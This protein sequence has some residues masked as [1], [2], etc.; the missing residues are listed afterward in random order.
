MSKGN[1]FT[2]EFKLEVLN[3]WLREVWGLQM[4]PNVCQ[5]HSQKDHTQ[6]LIK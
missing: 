2:E 5:L 3:K 6:V 1:R 4:F